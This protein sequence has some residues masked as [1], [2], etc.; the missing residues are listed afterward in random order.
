MR[1]VGGSN[2]AGGT[3]VGVFHPTRQLAGFSPP[4]MPY[5]VNLFRISPPGEPVNYRPCGPPPFRVTKP[6]KI[7]AI[8]AIIIIIIG[9]LYDLQVSTFSSIIQLLSDLIRFIMMVRCN[10]IQQVT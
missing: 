6:H 9:L 2:P 8:S 5:I 4:K 7:T 1:E 10:L 3:I